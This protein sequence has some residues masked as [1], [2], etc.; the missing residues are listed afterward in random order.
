MHDF[1]VDARFQSRCTISQSRCTI[2]QS[3]CFSVERLELRVWDSGVRVVDG[4]RLTKHDDVAAEE[5][6]ADENHGHATGHALDAR[7]V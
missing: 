4:V 7:L 2:S 1:R 6:I 3:R 5:D